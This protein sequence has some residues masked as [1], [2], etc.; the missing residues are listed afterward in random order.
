VLFDSVLSVMPNGT[1]S[2]SLLTGTPTTT[3]LPAG[4]ISFSGD[5]ITASV[6]GSLLPSNGVPPTAFSWNLWPRDTTQAGTAAI[7]DFAPDNSMIAVAVVP[8]PSTVALLALG[9]GALGWRARQR[10]EA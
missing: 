4:S 2:I 8:E 7:S 5:T 6:S 9:L 1:G 3:A 10:R